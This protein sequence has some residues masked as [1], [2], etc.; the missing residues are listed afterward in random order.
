M[1]S[2]AEE[3]RSR[4]KV[5]CIFTIPTTLYD[6]LF[7]PAILSVQELTIP[8]TFTIA[9]NSLKVFVKG[10]SLVRRKITSLFVLT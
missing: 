8:L 10:K 1:Y 9:C 2:P 3:K 7:H 6:Q 5:T 4:I